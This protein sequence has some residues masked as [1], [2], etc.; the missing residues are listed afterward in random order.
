MEKRRPDKTIVLYS[1][2]IWSYI[3]KQGKKVLIISVGTMASF[4]KKSLSTK[5]FRERYSSYLKYAKLFITLNSCKHY[6]AH[7]AFFY[8]TMCIAWKR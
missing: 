5:F 2:T 3:L 6:D 7:F 8:N 4:L 1:K